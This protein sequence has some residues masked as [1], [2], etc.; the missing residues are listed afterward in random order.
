MA[1]NNDVPFKMSE[2]MSNG[3]F[4][5]SNEEDTHHSLHKDDDQSEG[6]SM[7]IPRTHNLFLARVQLVSKMLKEAKKEATAARKIH[8]QHSLENAVAQSTK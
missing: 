3:Y 5:G 6:P 4:S 1:V 2:E 8:L 7:K